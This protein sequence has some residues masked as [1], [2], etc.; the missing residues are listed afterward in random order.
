MEWLNY[1]HLLYFWTVVR[2]GSISKAAKTLRLAQPTVSGQLRLLEDRLGHTLLERNSKAQTLTEVGKVVFRYADEIFGLG[3]EL[4][5]VLRGKTEGRPVRFAVGLVDSVP[6]LL[7]AQL[8]GPAFHV[9]ST[10]QVRIEEATADQLIPRL[11]A[12]DLDLIVSD[13]PANPVLRSKVWS[14]VLGECGVAF[15]APPA[16]ARTLKA[17]FPA[18]LQG[19][20]CVLP[21]PSTPLRASLEIFF[22]RNK[23]R[24]RVVAEVQDSALMKVLGHLGLGVFAAPTVSRPQV[25]RQFDVVEIGETNEVSERFFAIS[26]ER[27]IRHPAVIAMSQN[28]RQDLFPAKTGTGA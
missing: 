18:S 20:P 17:R 22:D 27:R 11:L 15:F 13:A 1:H 9:S 10:I 21:L 4:Q 14:H 24:P 19:A 12:H 3:R 23:V 2:E 5:D 7:A 28:A 8:L 16:L 25:L 26:A 6:K